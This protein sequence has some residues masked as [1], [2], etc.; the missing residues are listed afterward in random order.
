MS[1]QTLFVIYLIVIATAAAT[2]SKVVLA[3]RAAAMMIALLVA[4]LAYATSLGATGV[5]GRY[6]HLP[7]GLLVLVA[8]VIL[9]LLVL[10]LTAPGAHLASAIPLN[11]LLGFQVFRVGVEVSLQHLYGQGLAP[12]LLTL[13]GGNVEIL[14]ALTAPV[15]AWLVSRGPSGRRLAWI[16][17]LTGI[18]SLGNI[19]VCA[20]LTAPGPLHLIHAEV[21][22]MAIITYPFTFVPGFMVPLAL[23]LHVL[24]FRAFR[25][26]TRSRLSTA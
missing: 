2:I 17:N 25:T 23:A 18:L 3:P 9:I 10:T 1:F 12:R 22:D 8:P 21:P 4:W 7:P 14:I 20:V 13:E 11:V 15:A 24:A 26:A 16:W 6:D 19:V 5:V